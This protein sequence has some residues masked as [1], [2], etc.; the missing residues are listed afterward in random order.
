MLG[1]LHVVFVY[2]L[3]WLT[4]DAPQDTLKGKVNNRLQLR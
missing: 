3:G 2:D 4:E 1:V